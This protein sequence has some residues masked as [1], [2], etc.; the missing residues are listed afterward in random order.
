MIN[1]LFEFNFKRLNLE[2]VEHK[3]TSDV[4]KVFSVFFER[5]L[6]FGKTNFTFRF[7]FFFEFFILILFH[8]QTAVTNIVPLLFFLQKPIAIVMIAG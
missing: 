7:E 1:I 2:I 5:K 8:P 3:A 4:K 6:L